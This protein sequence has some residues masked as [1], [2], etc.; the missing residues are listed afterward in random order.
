MVFWVGN[1]WGNVNQWGVS[2]CVVGYFVG[3]IFCVGVVVVWLYDGGGYGYVVVV[4][5][6]VNNLFI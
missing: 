1:Y 4:M 3:I 2:V 5:L 6:V